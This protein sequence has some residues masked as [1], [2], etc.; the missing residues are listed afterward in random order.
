VLR[1]PEGL[2]RGGALLVLTQLHLGFLCGGLTAATLL[3]M[4]RPPCCWELLNLLVWM[5]TQ[6][7]LLGST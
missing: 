2:C 3:L 1:R 7:W 4:Q 6:P 5:L